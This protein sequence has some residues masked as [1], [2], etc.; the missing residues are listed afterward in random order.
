MG[1]RYSQLSLSERHQIARWRD[2]K[3]PVL[4]MARRLSRHVSTVHRELRRNRTDAGAWLRG[5]FSIAA[6][7]VSDLRR[8]RRTNLHSPG[9]AALRSYIVE[10]LGN[11]WS[12][13]QIAGYLLRTR[14]LNDYVF[15][16]TIYRYVYSAKGRAAGLSMPS[17]EMMCSAYP[18]APM[19]CHIP[20]CDIF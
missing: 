18:A 17:H 10:P 6:Q 3:V 5:Y 1:S 20:F 2:A 16:E 19:I 14:C 11:G 4:D 13:E 15:H 8:R 7:Q 9:F 12:P